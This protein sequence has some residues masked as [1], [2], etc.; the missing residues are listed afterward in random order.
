MKCPKCGDDCSRD[1]VDNGVG[2]IHGPYGCPSCAWSE[3]TEYDLSNGESP[4]DE[5]GGAF[6]QYGGYY[7]PRSMTALAYRLAENGGI[8]WWMLCRD[9]K[10]W[11][12]FE[13]HAL[14]EKA[15]TEAIEND[16]DQAYTW[17][18]SPMRANPLAPAAPAQN[19]LMEKSG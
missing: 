10:L 5:R 9:D 18:I 6:D 8:D 19:D 14:A 7:P 17:S 13:S 16:V 15:L 3:W 1:S 4:L 11:S 12:T 2:I